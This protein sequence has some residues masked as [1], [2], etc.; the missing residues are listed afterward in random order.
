MRSI[1]QVIRTKIPSLA[2]KFL[3]AIAPK[4]SSQIRGLMI[5]GCFSVHKDVEHNGIRLKFVVPNEVTEWRAS[6]FSTKEP[7]TLAW[8]DSFDDDGVFWDVGANVGAFSIYCAKKHPRMRVVAFEPSVM[9]LEVLARN[10]TSNGVQPQVCIVP[11]ALFDKTG[12]GEFSLGN[13]DRGGALSAYGVDFGYDGKA[14][15]KSLSY[16]TLGVTMDDAVAR[17]DIARPTYVKIDV[18]GIEHIIL[19]GGSSTLSSADVRSILIEINDDFSEQSAEAAKL[20]TAYGFTLKEKKH[21]AM[22][23]GGRYSKV[24]N[25]IWYRM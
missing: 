18:D 3:S 23:D 21:A 25:N 12:R 17:F 1:K 16:T 8:I 20:L 4:L 9:N 11:L 22:F 10:I 15:S 5:D 6:S 2:L 19:R 7:E 24:F 14:I 13:L